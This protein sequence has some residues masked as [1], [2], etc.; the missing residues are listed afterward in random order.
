M[1]DQHPTFVISTRDQTKAEQTGARLRKALA[2]RQVSAVLVRGPNTAYKLEDVQTAAWMHCAPVIAISWGQTTPEDG[3][4]GRVYCY[5][6]SGPMHKLAAGVAQHLASIKASIGACIAVP[7]RDAD[8]TPQVDEAVWMEEDVVRTIGERGPGAIHV[9]WW[10]VGAEPATVAAAIAEGVQA[11]MRTKSAQT[12]L[13]ARHFAG[14]LAD[15]AGV[16]LAEAGEIAAR[17]AAMGEKMAGTLDDV[18]QRLI[19]REAGGQGA[20]QAAPPRLEVPARTRRT[21]SGCGPRRLRST[22]RS[23][24]PRGRSGW[25]ARRP[26]GWASAPSSSSAPRSTSP[27][28]PSASLPRW[29]PRVASWRSCG[30]C[31]Y[32]PTP[33]PTWRTSR[34]GSSG[35]AAPLPD[36]EPPA[37]GHVAVSRVAVQRPEPPRHLR[38][39]VAVGRCVL[40]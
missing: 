21:R 26:A 34:R 12:F 4:R 29:G 6:S 8:D 20:E 14:S 11:W 39:G 25:C 18:A 31:S 17:E 27:R 33:A 9:V 19:P 10:D 32:T 37:L 36:A 7:L 13:E 38:H 22:R 2:G 35:A 24:R 28:W 23:C 30:G 5:E 15:T 3:H 40:M 16:D 1:A